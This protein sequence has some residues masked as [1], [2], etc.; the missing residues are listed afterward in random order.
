MT[1]LERVAVALLSEHTLSGWVQ[2][3]LDARVRHLLI[4]EFQ[5]TSPLQ[6]HALQS[7][8]AAYAGA[9]GGIDAPR[10]FIVG[11][12]KQS[13]Y[14][15]RR[16]EPRVFKAA[17]DFVVEALG[18]SRRRMRSHAALCAG[19]RGGRSTASSQAGTARAACRSGAITRP[20]SR[21]TAAHRR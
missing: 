14:R 20:R 13:I 2:Q 7:W 10:V 6:W 8:L 15:F 12:P 4:D 11:D 17:Q 1:D 3:R 21:T 16:A 19:R 9:G 5:D 18:G